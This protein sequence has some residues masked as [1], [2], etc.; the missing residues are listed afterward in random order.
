MTHNCTKC[1]TGMYLRIT[2]PKI[3]S[4]KLYSFLKLPN[5]NFLCYYYP[6]IYTK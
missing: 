6:S 1:I 4:S 5:Y 3:S 2:I